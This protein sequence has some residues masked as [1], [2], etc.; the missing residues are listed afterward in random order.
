MS[1]T[2]TL[3]TFNYQA[4]CLNCG[5]AGNVYTIKHRAEAAADTHN[6]AWHT[7]EPVIINIAH[8][9]QPATITAA[10]RGISYRNGA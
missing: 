4:K 5:W 9:D 10:Q 2:V 7:G 8:T 3:T 1:A 6:A